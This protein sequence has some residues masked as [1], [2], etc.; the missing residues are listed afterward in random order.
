MFPLVF[1]FPL[2]NSIYTHVSCHGFFHA[3]QKE[4]V[5]FLIT[6]ST[7]S[8]QHV[9]KPARRTGEL[10]DSISTLSYFSSLWFSKTI[11]KGMGWALPSGNAAGRHLVPKTQWCLPNMWA[12]LKV[13]LQE[14]AAHRI[15]WCLPT[16]LKD[17]LQEVPKGDK[18]S[19][20]HH[21]FPGNLC[22]HPRD[23]SALRQCKKVYKN[24][25]PNLTHGIISLQVTLQSPIC[26]LSLLFSM[27]KFSTNKIFPTSA[28]GV[29]LCFHSQ[30]GLKNPEH[31]KF[32]RLLSVH[33]WWPW[34]DQP[35]PE[36]DI[37]CAK[38]GKTA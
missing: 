21:S 34:W 38:L 25:I 29:C 13:T 30:R 18:W 4:F 36:V 12:L 2:I 16:Q 33:I 5:S 27:N 35:S 20:R 22:L 6:N 17:R 8:H 32:L 3:G 1:P 9:V 19:R 37:G 24:P 15:Q 28:V 7:V 10:P 23:I 26:S 14:R 11:A 31:L